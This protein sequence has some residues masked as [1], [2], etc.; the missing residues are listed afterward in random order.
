MK[1]PI[2]I[3]FFLFLIFHLFADETIL[4]DFESSIVPGSVA[5]WLSYSKTGTSASQWGAANPNAEGINPTSGCYRIVKTS[6]DP[7]WTGLEVTLSNPVSITAANLYLHIL[8]YK[9]TG[10]RIALTY[11]PAGGSQSSDLWQSNATTGSWVDYV[12]TLP[13]G[14]SLKTFAIKIADDPG[15]YFFDQIRLSD[16]GTS[17]SRTV[18]SIDPAKTGQTIE[19]W[20]G[21][22]CWWANMM[23]GF[24]D[25]KIKALC[26]WITDPVNGLNMNIFRFNIG[27]GD[28]PDHQHMRGDG[29][30]MP[31][32]KA[33]ATADY[34]WSQ[35]ASQRKILRQL[36]ASRLEKAGVNDIQL[37]AFSN[38]PPYWM[39]RSACSAGSNEGN[40]CNLKADMFDDFADYLTEVVRYYHD[41]L[42]ITF[43]YLEPFNEPDGS[44]WKAGG[45]QE[46]CYFSNNDQLVMIREL[47]AKL[48]QKDM[49]SYCRINANDANN[50]D[51]GYSSFLNYQSAGDIL[52]MI[53]LLSV[54][55]YGGSKRSLLASLAQNTN[56]K[57]WQS[58][59]GPLNVGGTNEHQIMVVADRIITDIRDMKCT[60]WIDWQ[61]GATGSPTNNPWGLIIGDYVFMQNPVTRNINYYIRAQFSRYFKPGY[62]IVSSSEP[63]TLAALSPDGKELVVLISNSESYTRKYTLDLTPFSDF[64]KAKQIRTRAQYDLGIRNSEERYTVSGNSLNY[65][66]LP[67]SVATYCIPVNQGN[68]AEYFEHD[69]GRYYYANGKLYTRFGSPGQVILQVFDHTGRRVGAENFI[70]AEG[71]TPLSLKEGIYLIYIRKNG[72]CYAKKIV[73]TP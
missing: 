69:P 60:A 71:R 73:V 28:N 18:V 61:I 55:S 64:G 27:G 14:I 48:K 33:S 13:S 9:T 23:G 17:L 70:P 59:S 6:Q 20:G 57:L 45:N 4:L 67:E 72:S 2:L 65:D 16:S 47:Y 3:V 40:V 15:E 7:Y 43:N 24:S 56:K 66:A 22:L 1:K 36:L 38:S 11:T 39:T 62:Q 50:M 53:D 51:N 8:V 44:W 41:Q 49:L 32:Y 29:G 25:A 37:V 42:G 35:D 31:G 12:L 58:E 5:S 54:H 68:S 63:N 34:D 52:P 10:S 30:D 19:G 46:G 21:S 26:D